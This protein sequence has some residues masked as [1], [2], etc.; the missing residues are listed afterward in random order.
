MEEEGYYLILF[1]RNGKEVPVHFDEGVDMSI[2][3]SDECTFKYKK[4]QFNVP[5]VHSTFKL[6]DGE[7]FI[8]MNDKNYNVLINQ[9]KL[10][11][12]KK[13]LKENDIIIIEP[14]HL[15]EKKFKIVYH[16]RKVKRI[17]FE[18]DKKDEEN[19]R[20]KEELKEINKSREKD[21]EEMKEL[22]KENQELKLELKNQKQEFNK[23]IDLLF[24]KLEENEKIIKKCNEKWN[25]RDLLLIDEF[26]SLLDSI[27]SKVLIKFK[28]MNESDSIPEEF[29]DQ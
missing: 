14:N 11:E 21:V 5:K 10:K 25:Q 2:G 22:K 20:L 1:Q 27:K 18:I 16:K 24:K 28:E 8:F 17:K 19:E 15:M 13:K 3:S 7:P 29:F 23:E 6:I 12:V 4:I 9:D 26:N